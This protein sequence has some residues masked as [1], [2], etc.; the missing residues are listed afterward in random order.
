MAC[1]PGKRIFGELERR[2]SRS[3]GEVI[4]WRARYTGPDTQRH[5]RLFGDK[6]AADTWL[7]DERIL[8]DR[9]EWKPPK[10]REMEAR[11]AQQRAIT[12]REWAERSVAN[13]RLRPS[14]GAAT[15]WC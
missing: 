4:G 7:N 1:G 5:S 6:M 11:L 9:G 12:L 8:I 2:R 14:S 15:R 3:T 10:V 13:K